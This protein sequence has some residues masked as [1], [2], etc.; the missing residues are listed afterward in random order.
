MSKNKNYSVSNLFNE[1]DRVADA[2]FSIS[3]NSTTTPSWVGG[4]IIG[5]PIP[6]KTWDLP[7]PGP[8]SI[9]TKE[10]Y[11]KLWD[12]LGEGFS[13]LYG[14]KNFPPVNIKRDREGTMT[15]EFALAGFDKNLFEVTFEDSK[16]V[17]KVTQPEGSEENEEVIYLHKGIKTKTD[18]HY[19][20]PLALEK[21]DIGKTSAKF[22]N[23]ILTVVIPRSEDAKPQKIKIQ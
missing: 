2:V 19:T 17:L 4:C 16:L 18:V 5:D 1:L 10:P 13:K 14:N 12:V 23:G 15:F 20:Y 22:E 21:F 9:K 3:T 6:V 7:Y 8:F 11:E